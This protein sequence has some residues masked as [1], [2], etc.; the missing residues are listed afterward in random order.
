MNQKSRKEFLRGAIQLGSSLFLVSAVFDSIS[1]SD[2]SDAVKIIDELKPISEEEPTAKA[3]G[4]HHDAKN[5]NFLIYPDRKKKENTNQVCANCA[6]F[7]KG[8]DG[9]GKCNILTAGLVS[10]KGWCSAWSQRS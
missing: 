1:A 10:N 4:F 6:Q 8:K 7:S 9:Y 2:E 5:T 3:L